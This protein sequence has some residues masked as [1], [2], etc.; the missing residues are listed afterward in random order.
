MRPALP[1]NGQG[2]DP[3]TAAINRRFGEDAAEKPPAPGPAAKPI[4]MRPKEANHA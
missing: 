3:L 1:G 4:R 2:V